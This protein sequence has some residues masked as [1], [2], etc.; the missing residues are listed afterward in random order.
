MSDSSDRVIGSARVVSACTGLSRI[1]GLVREILMASLF[2]TSLAKS[3]FDVAFCLPN[4]FRRL[5]GEGALS[6]SF[7][8]VFS[9]S[10]EKE[11]VASASRLASRVAGM[12]AAVLS[13]VVLAGVVLTLTIPHI[14]TPNE[15]LAAILPLLRIMLPYTLFIC[16]VALCMAI[17][18]SFH[19]FAVPAATPVVLN[20]VWIAVLV[21][22]CPFVGKT[23]AERIVVVAWGVVLA[24]VVQ[25]VVQVPMLRR[26]GVHLRLSF[27]WHDPRI[28]QMLIL[29]GPAALGMGVMQINVLI[30]RVLA[31]M[32]GAWAPAALTYSERLL[33]L[34]LGLFA[35]AMGTVLLPAFS[36]QAARGEHEQMA[37]TLENSTQS[38]MLIVMPAAVGMLVLASPIVQLV[39]EWKHGEFGAESTLY[40]VRALR[41]Y[42]LGLIPFSFYKLIVPVFYALKDTRTPVRVG[43]MMA[44]L[45]LV[46]NIIFVLTWPEGYGHAGLA[47]ATVIA[48][49]VNCSMLTRRLGRCLG[50][51]EWRG[52]VS[53]LLRVSMAALVMGWVAPYLH[54]F[55][56]DWLAGLMEVQKLQQ[57]LTVLL[58]II[59]G[60]GLYGLLIWALCRDAALR[61]IRR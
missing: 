28:H 5:F 15:R 7:I 14:V 34:P 30:D 42:A 49:V 47:C 1:L 52:T 44:G 37:R 36:R 59:T 4:L 39:F 9:D 54:N 29:M 12:M 53:V 6:A 60:M 26:H 45:N 58:T 18:N 41:F 57:V 27:Q 35:T 23:L 13:L 24:G 19:H 46:L 3:A 43:M 10:L 55:L 25:L 8:P 22:V 2:G 31:M 33:Y 16:L 51:V 61:L 50:G 48:S 56:G 20:L 11:G 38:L 17:L 21:L 40:T 32:V